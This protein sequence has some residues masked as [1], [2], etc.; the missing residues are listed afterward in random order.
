MHSPSHCQHC[1]KLVVG[2][3]R[4]FCLECR[5]TFTKADNRWF[6]TEEPLFHSTYFSLVDRHGTIRGVYDGT[7]KEAIN[8]LFKNVA[9][10]LKER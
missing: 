7:D 5:E 4:S 8:R 2:E 1:K 10:L 6:S 3:T 9:E